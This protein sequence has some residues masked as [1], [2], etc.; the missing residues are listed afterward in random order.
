MR[1]DDN[2]A[3]MTVADEFIALVVRA[4]DAIANELRWLVVPL[5][6]AAVLSAQANDDGV[7]RLRV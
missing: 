6:V 5:V 2:G 3:L 4:Y 7:V 1:T